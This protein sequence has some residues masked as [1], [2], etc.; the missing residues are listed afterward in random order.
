MAKGAQKLYEIRQ[1]EI[2]PEESYF[3]KPVMAI[4]TTGRAV[5]YP[6][7]WEGGVYVAI[8]LPGGEVVASYFPHTFVNSRKQPDVARTKDEGML[9]ASQKAILYAL[10]WIE[11]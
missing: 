11:K 5:S 1:Q 4:A 10:E 3:Q 6:G 9:V 2:N 8:A 7:K